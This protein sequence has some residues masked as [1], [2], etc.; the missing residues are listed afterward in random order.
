MPKQMSFSMA[1]IM[2]VATRGTEISPAGNL[3]APRAL[4]G[5]SSQ[6]V[7]AI[8]VLSDTIAFMERLACEFSLESQ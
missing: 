1:D 5:G 8:K 6:D 3:C 4:L 2:S 7:S